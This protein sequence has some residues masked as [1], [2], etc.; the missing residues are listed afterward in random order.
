MAFYSV[1]SYRTPPIHR[2]VDNIMGVVHFRTTGER[3]LPATATLTLRVL[4]WCENGQYSYYWRTA[5][6]MLK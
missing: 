5:K 6:R 4:L 2:E 1:P 3:A